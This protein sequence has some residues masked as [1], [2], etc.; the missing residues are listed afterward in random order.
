VHD[1]ITR[2][3][4][5]LTPN[6]GFGKW[7]YNFFDGQSLQS[8]RTTSFYDAFSQ[9]WIPRV[10]LPTLINRI[11]DYNFMDQT[12]ALHAGRA[13]QNYMTPYLERAESE[14]ARFS[15][16]MYMRDAFEKFLGIQ[17]RDTLL[18]H[19]LI[20]TGNMSPKPATVDEYS[21]P[22][23]SIHRSNGHLPIP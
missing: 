15:A 9:H 5:N 18:T 2:K 8:I 20:Y 22:H 3:F 12:N 7:L 4:K 6:Q 10:Q 21:R 13:F 14:A 17:V 1:A 16:E 23:P 11:V 19:S